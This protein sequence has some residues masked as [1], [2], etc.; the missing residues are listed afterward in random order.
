MGVWLCMCHN[1]MKFA[2]L[3]NVQKAIKIEYSAFNLAYVHNNI[4]VIIFGH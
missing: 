4:N 3:N 1:G 2:T